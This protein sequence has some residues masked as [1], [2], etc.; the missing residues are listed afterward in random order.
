MRTLRLIKPHDVVQSEERPEDLSPEAA[1]ARAGASPGEA[2]IQLASL[3]TP[4]RAL[5]RDRTD[6]AITIE[7]DLPWLTIGTVVHADVVGAVEQTGLVQSFAVEVTSKGSARL[8]I[9][10]DLSRADSISGELR[11]DPPPRP[12]RPWWQLMMATLLV[13]AAVA[14][15]YT[16]GP[17]WARL[18]SSSG[19]Q[20]AP[21]ASV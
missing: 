17:R 6:S 14:A 9:T 12:A 5:I 11:S 15:G 3:P 20:P 10:I 7:A 13:V 8:L 2:R 1:A 18:H 16:L 19:P 21:Q 4:L